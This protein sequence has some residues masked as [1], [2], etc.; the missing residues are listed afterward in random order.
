[1][2]IKMTGKYKKLFAALDGVEFV[3]HDEGADVVI[4]CRKKS[5]H[6]WVTINVRTGGDRFVSGGVIEFS[7]LSENSYVSVKRYHYNGL[8]AL[9]DHNGKLDELVKLVAKIPVTHWGRIA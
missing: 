8:A 9:A 7:Y 6:E 2:R 5:N 3:G 4:D 1:V